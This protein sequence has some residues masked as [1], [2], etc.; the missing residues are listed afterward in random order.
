MRN[1]FWRGLADFMPGLFSAV[2][3]RLDARTALIMII[4]IM[5]LAVLAAIWSRRRL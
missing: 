1:A 2:A 5:L 4:I 3:G